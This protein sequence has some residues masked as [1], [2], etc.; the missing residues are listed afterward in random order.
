MSSF[1]LTIITAAAAAAAVVV[2]DFLSL[3]TPS[4]LI[5]WSLDSFLFS[6]LL[7]KGRRWDSSS[8]RGVWLH[9]SLC[10]QLSAL[11]L[12]VIIS[13]IFCTRASIVELFCVT[14]YFVLEHKRKNK[15]LKTSRASYERERLFASWLSTVCVCVYV[16]MLFSLPPFR[17][18]W[19]HYCIHQGRACP[20]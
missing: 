7:P 9:D 12:C 19:G 4:T 8:L 5:D 16:V 10:K 1:H 11:R 17:K 20:V 3:S 15:V 13:L 18:S 14:L 6:F 2:V